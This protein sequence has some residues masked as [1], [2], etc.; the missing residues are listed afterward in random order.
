MKKDVVIGDKHIQGDGLNILH[1]A[2]ETKNLE[3]VKLICE[4]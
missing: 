4:T 1:W 2:V 3:A